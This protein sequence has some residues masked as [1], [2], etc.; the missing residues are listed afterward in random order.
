MNLNFFPSSQTVFSRVCPLFGVAKVS[1]FG[2]LKADIK[3]ATADD[4]DLETWPSRMGRC[5]TAGFMTEAVIWMINHIKAYYQF[6]SNQIKS[7]F[8]KS[9]LCDRCWGS[10][11]CCCQFRVCRATANAKHF[12]FALRG[13]EWTPFAATMPI[14]TASVV[15]HV[16][17]RGANLMSFACSVDLFPTQGF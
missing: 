15:G 14:V 12:H 11:S 8:T 4:F 13:D 1:F 7:T 9:F 5:V 10:F 16:K 6:T 2:T 3:I 17:T